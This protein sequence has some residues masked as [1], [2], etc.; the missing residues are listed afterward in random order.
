M[1]LRPMIGRDWMFAKIHTTHAYVGVVKCHDMTNTMAGRQLGW[2]QIAVDPCYESFAMSVLQR[3]C[4]Y[5]F[6]FSGLLFNFH[7]ARHDLAQ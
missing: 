7:V 6:E 1:N 3:L 5:A 2:A 4:T